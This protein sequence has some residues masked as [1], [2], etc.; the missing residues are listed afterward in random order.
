M[1][2]SQ[3]TGRL[4]SRPKILHFTLLCVDSSILPVE[5]PSTQYATSLTIP[6]DAEDHGVPYSPIFCHVQERRTQCT[7]MHLASFLNV[8][9]LSW[10]FRWIPSFGCSKKVY[11]IDRIEVRL[12][13]RL[14]CLSP[15]PICFCYSSGTR[16]FPLLYPVSPLPTNTTSKFPSFLPALVI[17]SADSGPTPTMARFFPDIQGSTFLP[18][19]NGDP[20]SQAG[21]STPRV[22]VGPV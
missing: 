12:Y 21:Y 3:I 15:P 17:P 7:Q 6:W 13:S 10:A 4:L 16:R 5:R 22:W 9:T 8:P 1:R 2:E 18:T 19:P 20:P 11:R 14:P